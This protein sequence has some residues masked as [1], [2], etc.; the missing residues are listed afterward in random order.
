[1]DGTLAET[2]KHG[3]RVAFN[4]AF[5]KAGLDDRWGEELYGELLNVAGGR[6][7]ILSYFK[8]RRDSL[9]EDPEQLAAELHK[10]K[11]AEF[12]ELL[13]NGDLE[14][15]PGIL[16]LIQELSNAGVSLAIAT[17]GTRSTVIK[18]LECLKPGL[19]TQFEAILTADEAPRKKPDPQVYE[20]AL[21]ELGVSANEALAIEDSRDGLLAA[22][23]AG[24]PCLVATAEY[25]I[26]KKFEEAALLTDGLGEPDAPANALLDPHGI[27]STEQLVVDTQLLRELVSISSSA[28]QT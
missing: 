11:V 17:T 2:E 25:N 12:R 13:S 22:T 18:I 24:L 6:E 3:H 20:L 15:R 16:R 23:S 19:S 28:Q 27:S 5:E 7:R 4:R 8:S 14:A 9:S 26:G 21:S 1:M 10:S